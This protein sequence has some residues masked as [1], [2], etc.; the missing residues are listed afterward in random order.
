MKLAALMRKEFYRFFHD[1]RLIIAVLIPG[2]IIFLVYTVLGSILSSDKDETY[3]YRVFLSGDSVAVSLIGAAVEESG[4]TVEWVTATDAESA[5]SAVEN[6]EAT[7]F[8]A[9]SDG[10]DTAA[11]E[12]ELYYTSGETESFSF[13]SIASALLREYGMRYRFQSVDLADESQ[14][15]SQFMGAFLPM[16]IVCF[17]FTASMG[18]TVESVAGEKERGTIATILATSVKRSHVALGKIIP[19]ACISLLGAASGFFGIVFSMPRLMGLSIAVFDFGIRNYI[20]LF[21]LTVSIVPFIVACIALVSTY[22]K[23]VKEATAYVSI[24]MIFFIVLSV[25]AGIA[26]GIGE[27]VVAVP[28]LNATVV[29]SLLLGGALPVWQTLV[30][31]GCNLVYTALLVFLIAKM[32][33]SERIMFR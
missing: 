2:V 13:G 25:V 11:G 26:T 3:A 10:F 12:V 4:N 17:T 15:Q 33:Q 7:A 21:F 19:L 27:W 16:L 22:A 18:I 20:L 6:G 24:I 30:S 1:P 8:L 32:F 5:K 9:F 14:L 29:M 28:V 31:V 23:T